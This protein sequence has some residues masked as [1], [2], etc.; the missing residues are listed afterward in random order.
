MIRLPDYCHVL[1]CGGSGSGKGVSIVLPNLLTYRRGSIICFDTKGDLYEI[2]AKRRAAMGDRIVQVAPFNGGN[3]KCNPL[4][5]IPCD[6]PLLVDSANAMATALVTSDGTE[7]DPHWNQKSVQVIR[8]V[9]V[10]VLLKF[11][12][13]GSALL[14]PCRRSSATRTC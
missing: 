13:R 2:T 5:T 12:D 9:L 6:S 1:C 11:K 14:T 8:A 7:P 4:D 3:D 10:L